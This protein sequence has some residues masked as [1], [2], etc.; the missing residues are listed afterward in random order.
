M[1]YAGSLLG[2]NLN[3]HAKPEGLRPWLDT[4]GI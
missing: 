4:T 2:R 1:P 3:V